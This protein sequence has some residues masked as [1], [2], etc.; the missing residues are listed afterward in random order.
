M[1][2]AFQCMLNGFHLSLFSSP[3]FKGRRRAVEPNF[4]HRTQLHFDFRL[5]TFT[6]ELGEAARRSASGL[7]QSSLLLWLKSAV[8]FAFGRTASALGRCT[9]IH[10]R[11]SALSP[12]KCGMSRHV[13]SV[14]SLPP[15]MQPPARFQVELEISMF[16]YLSIGVNNR[17]KVK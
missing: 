6:G 10:V 7:R 8:A 15:V 5:R 12:G 1:L 9:G 4:R 3:A 17:L 2:N 11:L 14:Y 16:V 13:Y